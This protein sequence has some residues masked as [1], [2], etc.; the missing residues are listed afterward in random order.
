MPCAA[1]Y[2][3]FERPIQRPA[4]NL[5]KRKAVPAAVA[6]AKAA[7]KS[8]GGELPKKVVVHVAQGFSAFNRGALLK[9][10]KA[11][12]PKLPPVEVRDDLALSPTGRTLQYK[13]A[14]ARVRDTRV[15]DE[16]LHTSST[17]AEFE[18]GV[19]SGSNAASWVQ[20]LGRLYDGNVVAQAALEALPAGE[21]D[22]GTLHVW[23]TRRLLGT[24][25]PDGMRY[26]A[27]F[28]VFGYPTVFRVLG[29]ALAPAPSVEATLMARELGKRGATA[30][31]IEELVDKEFPE[32]RVDVD[33]PATVTGAVASA[34]LQAAAR[35]AGAGP[36]CDDP[37]CRLFNAHRKREVRDA[38][39]GGRLC[40][41]HAKLFGAS[42]KAK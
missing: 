11:S 42:G 10:L 39:L 29:L 1:I 28:A 34:I 37:K 27:R 16:F 19:D 8:P 35:D 4:R 33:D 24:Y 30:G 22:R 40:A 15:A 3:P 14:G 32:E 38:M 5:L 20:L 23:V 26:H 41:A 21:R 12:A 36:F 13:V 9:D 18:A 31:Q 7:A 25:D 17:D 2:S 6:K